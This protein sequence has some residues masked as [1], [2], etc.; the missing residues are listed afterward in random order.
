M[1]WCNENCPWSDKDEENEEEEEGKG[2]Q[3]LRR[4]YGKNKPKVRFAVNLRDLPDAMSSNPER[5]YQTVDFL[6]KLAPE[7]ISY[8]IYFYIYLNTSSFV[9]VIITFVIHTR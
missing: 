3:L 6:T 8:N 9:E 2:S 5:V 1:E 4:L 7:V